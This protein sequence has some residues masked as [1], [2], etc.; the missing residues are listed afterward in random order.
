MQS[1]RAARSAPD[2]SSEAHGCIRTRKG[3]VME[4]GKL[5]VAHDFDTCTVLDLWHFKHP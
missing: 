3:W 4:V 1:N 2:W 5:N